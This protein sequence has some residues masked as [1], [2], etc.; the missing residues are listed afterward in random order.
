MKC[1]NTGKQPNG[2]SNNSFQNGCI[3]I[4]GNGLLAQSLPVFVM[5]KLICHGYILFTIDAAATVPSTF[6]KMCCLMK[7]VYLLITLVVIFVHVKAQDPTVKKIQSEVTRTVKKD[8]TD[9]TEWTWKRGGTVS[10]NMTQ[11][12][13]RNWAAGGDN[14]SLALNSYVNYFLF[15]KKGKQSWDN[16]GEFN[17][18]MV[19]TTSLGSRKNDDRFDILSKY[20]YNFDGK[21]Y[22]TGLFNFR[23]QFFDGYTYSGSRATFSSTFLAPAYT[24]T[25]VG[26]DYKRTNFSAFVSP[27]TSRVIIVA[28]KRLS[29]RGLYGVPPGRR[30]FSEMGA[31]A[32]INYNQLLP[33]DINYKG[34]LDLFSNYLN[35]P[36]NIDVFMTNYFAFK[37]NKYL[38]ATYTL[39][40][41]YD[42]DVKLFGEEK[43]SPSLQLKSVMGIGFLMRI[44]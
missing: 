6:E 16:T 8:A 23:T 12:S 11:G 25:S 2:K 43:N 24:L 37:I 30:S 41:I 13:L 26:I 5:C 3:T 21:F 33:K 31:F 38:S 42:D 18:G 19:Q 28:S 9:T 1:E 35:K 40:L 27:L 36:G 29:E 17:F 10:V 44:K 20:G 39:D 34:R 7:Q 22:L 32:T 14:F 15:Y 4:I